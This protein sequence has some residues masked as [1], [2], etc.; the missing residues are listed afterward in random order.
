MW[1]LCGADT[2]LPVGDII[3]FG[4]IVVLGAIAL[5]AS[6]NSTPRI[7]YDEAYASVGSPTPNNGDDDEDEEDDYYDEDDNFG[8][9]RKIGKPKG[10]TPGNNRAQNEQFDAVAKKLRLNKDQRQLLHRRVG[11]EGYGYQGILEAARQ[12]FPWI[13]ETTRRS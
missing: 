7:E 11:G 4:G 9:R 5:E 13:I 10:Q 2:V 6:E 1:W 3:Y 12:L 8:G